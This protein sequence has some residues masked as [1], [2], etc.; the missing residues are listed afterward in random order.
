MYFMPPPTE[1]GLPDAADPG[2]LKDFQDRLRIS[3][4]SS[5]GAWICDLPITG[6]VHNVDPKPNTPFA[7]PRGAKL[8]VAVS[9]GRSR[10]VYQDAMSTAL[11]GVMED[12]YMVTV[13]PRD[14]PENVLGYNAVDA[15]IWL[16]AD[17]AQITGG[18][19]DKYR[20]LE[21]YIRRGGKL[22]ICHPMEWQKMLALDSL[23]PVTVQGVEEKPDLSP[24][25]EMAKA[26]E[27]AGDLPLDAADPM[28]SLM[29]PFRF[30]RAKAKPDT[31]VEDWITWK[32][33]DYS[34][35]LVRSQFGLGTVTWVAQD[36]G[37][38]ALTRTKYGWVY[39]WNHIF[40]WKNAPLPVSS[41]TTNAIKHPYD[42]GYPMDIGPS[43]VQHWDGPLKSQRWMI[44][45]A[46]MFF[47]GYWL[48]AGPGTY[49]WL[50]A[51]GRAQLSWFFF[52]ASALLAT[53]LT[54]VLVR[55]MLRGPPE[56]KHLS[57]VRVAPGQ[58]AVVISRF[59]LY[60][61]RDGYQNIE[62]RDAAPQSVTDISGFPIDPV[63][64][65]DADVPNQTGPEYDVP[66]VDQTSSK[67]AAISVKYRSTLKKFQATWV[68]AL[69]GA[70][71]GSGRLIA[72]RHHRRKNH[73]RYEP[74]SQDRL[75]CF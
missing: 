7:T 18:D 1:G 57:L 52:G 62:L 56:L 48:I 34:P 36:L 10:P 31:V 49:A 9:D 54:V 61:P 23:L 47:I 4:H 2:A 60:I 26:P 6:T 29:P 75:Y 38:P 43:V 32:A 71:T 19:D 45:V 11:L 66:I 15:V 17:P 33:D 50:A 42:Q 28:S 39:V 14:L 51:R 22:V 65:R 64:L 74:E 35:Y 30:V 40:D 67:P 72:R 8:I 37:D 59:G 5:S 63:F 20:A 27:E 73:Q 44:T 3:L 12:V 46:V 58:P 55:V 70:V 53:A 69:P 25:R 13:H 24:L 21:S 16:D 68:G 41:F